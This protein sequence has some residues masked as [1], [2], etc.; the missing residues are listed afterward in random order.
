MQ[1]LGETALLRQPV[2]NMAVPVT[3]RH[4]LV[5]PET[6]GRDK[7]CGYHLAMAECPVIVLFVVHFFQKVIDQIVYC[8]NFVMEHFKF[9]LTFA[10][11]N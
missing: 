3:E 2:E 11:Q 8:H 9:I 6:E 10:Y 1:A 4:G 7:G 5:A